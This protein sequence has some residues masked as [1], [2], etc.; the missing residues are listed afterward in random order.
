MKRMLVDFSLHHFRFHLEPKGALH[1]PAY[2]R[3]MGVSKIRD[4]GERLR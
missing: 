2:D 3:A 1:M 4:P